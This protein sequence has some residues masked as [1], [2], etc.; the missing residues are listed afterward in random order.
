MERSEGHARVRE[1]ASQN[2]PGSTAHQSPGGSR[3]R[4]LS[5]GKGRRAGRGLAIAVAL[6]GAFLVAALLGVGTP[7]PLVAAPSAPLSPEGQVIGA[8]SLTLNVTLRLAGTPGNAVN[9]S[10]FD[11]GNLLAGSVDL[12]TSEG[13]NVIALS[14]L[15]VSPGTPVTLVVTYLP[16]QSG[17]GVGD[18]PAWM[19]WN[20]TGTPTLSG[21]A[22]HN[23]TEEQ[24]G[25]YLW[26]VSFTP[27]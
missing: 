17:S 21:E 8:P 10:V 7:H 15:S 1:S 22:F 11:S 23:F 19:D 12:R 2:Q 9:L 20:L 13:P 14:D 25:T 6:G 4:G 24:P 3:G 16:G 5:G 18:N 27:P 26:E